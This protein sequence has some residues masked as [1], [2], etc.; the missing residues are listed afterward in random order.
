MSSEYLF[1]MLFRCINNCARKVSP[2]KLMKLE[3]FC[4]RI[5]C[6]TIATFSWTIHI[7]VTNHQGV[8][9]WEE[10][11]N[12][13]GLIRTS[14]DTTQFS[15][16]SVDSVI[17]VRDG[18]KFQIKVNSFD[19]NG[20]PREQEVY[21]FLVNSP[22]KTIQGTDSGCKVTPREGAA[23]LTDFYVTCLGWYDKDTPLRYSFKYTFSSS[24]VIIQ[25]GSI[26]NVTS[27]LPLGD[28]NKDYER[29]L[30]LQIIDAFGEYTSAFVK[31]KVRVLFNLCCTK[32]PRPHL[33][34]EYFFDKRNLYY[35]CRLIILISN[36]FAIII[37][38][39]TIIV[40]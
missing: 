31:T 27:K 29:I 35:S 17:P 6:A 23:I 5:Q 15:I 19:N 14:E 16:S 8:S 20:Q 24:T 33:S 32:L 1:S 4:G 9:I 11:K 40:T 22:P 21:S 3:V 28:P 26:G 39:V 38:T 36:I 34:K 12:A 30:E 2:N 7:L 18:Q 25:D 37:L 13:S 10:L